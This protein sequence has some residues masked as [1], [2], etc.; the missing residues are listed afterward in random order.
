MY[1]NPSN[2][3]LDLNFEKA[4]FWFEQ[5]ALLEDWESQL[6]VADYLYDGKGEKKD[7][8]K[9]FELYLE[10]SKDKDAKALVWSR[11]ARS[12]ENGTGIEKDPIKAFELYQKAAFMED[13][14]ALFWFWSHRETFATEQYITDPNFLRMIGYL[15]NC[16]NY[17][18][19]YQYPDPI[20]N[21]IS[22]ELEVMW[23][24]RKTDE[25]YQADIIDEHFPIELIDSLR[26][27]LF[28]YLKSSQ[29]PLT[30]V[31][32][33]GYEDDLNF[34]LFDINVPTEFTDTGLTQLYAYQQFNDSYTSHTYPI[35][36]IYDIDHDG[37]DEYIFYYHPSAG[38]ITY[39]TQNCTIHKKGTE[40]LYQSFDYFEFT[41]YEG[42]DLAR[43]NNNFYFVK[44]LYAPE[45]LNFDDSS[46]G[47]N[48]ISMK[49]GNDDSQKELSVCKDHATPKNVFYI[50]NEFEDNNINQ[51]LTNDIQQTIDKQAID[52]I[53]SSKNH[54][55]YLPKFEKKSTW[56]YENAA[57]PAD[58]IEIVDFEYRYD[59]FEYHYNEVDYNNDGKTEILQ[60]IRYLPSFWK[61]TN[62]YLQFDFLEN[63]E[64][65]Q[66][67]VKI[68]LSKQSDA[69]EL[70][71]TEYYS[72]V[73]G[74]II[75]KLPLTIKDKPKIAQFWTYEYDKK[76]FTM[77]LLKTGSSYRLYTYYIQNDDFYLLSQS[78]YFDMPSSII[79]SV[80]NYTK[81]Y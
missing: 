72:D 74:N 69:Y 32:N 55:L 63:T 39:A 45:A 48:L 29:N 11:L 30:I 18:L 33:N 58:N 75:D 2:Q 10:L 71:K 44:Y 26:F 70:S 35:Y 27:T 38:G 14:T 40:N 37:E 81:D 20:V 80:S 50:Q 54:E 43:F 59:Y 52:A 23:K 61:N 8:Q 78:C 73:A 68:D 4:L 36:M 3:Y 5:G 1:E 16:A 17:E 57:T 66:E 7:Q 34:D 31:A 76:T 64:N 42:G 19:Y 12:Y 41:G 6:K 65:W 60:R 77:V 15:T 56:V 49:Q 47:T 51:L 28:S 53:K 79:A 21:D 24:N 9:A 67:E 46:Y 25:F 62:E 13:P 22:N